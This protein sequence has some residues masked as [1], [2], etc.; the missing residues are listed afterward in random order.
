LQQQD[1]LL[2]VRRLPIT[3]RLK[4]LKATG[5]EIINARVVDDGEVITAAGVTSGL[6]LALWV[7]ERYFNSETAHK[8]ETMLEYE[9]RG[10]VWR[11]SVE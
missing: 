7:L 10:P 2:V 11:W 5:A 1:F 9:R 6:D 8:V 4:N 3:Q